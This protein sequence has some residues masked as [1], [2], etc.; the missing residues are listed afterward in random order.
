MPS[1]WDRPPSVTEG[2]GNPTAE[3]KNITIIISITIT[4]GVGGPRIP[5]AR[6]TTIINTHEHRDHNTFAHA[7]DWTVMFGAIVAQVFSSS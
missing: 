5:T 1:E 3:Q 4:I 6:C 7:F 2:V